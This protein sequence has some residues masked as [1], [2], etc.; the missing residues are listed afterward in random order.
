M[1]LLTCVLFVIAT[2]FLLS[3]DGGITSP[4]QSAG[5]ITIYPP[6][7][8]YCQGFNAYLKC[9]YSD[10]VIR[11]TVDGTEPNENSPIYINPIPITSSVWLRTKSYRKNR[12]PGSGSKYFYINEY[13]PIVACGNSYSGQCAIPTNTNFLDVRAGVNFSLAIKSDS[14]LIAWGSWISSP[15]PSG[16]DYKAIAAGDNHCLAL[17]SNGS[18][19]AWGDNSEGQCNRPTGFG[20]KAIDANGTLW[21]E[22]NWSLAIKSDG[23][24][25][26][27]GNN[28]YGQCNV[29]AGNH[30]VKIATGTTHGLALKDD[31]SIICWGKNDMGQTTAPP[32][33]NYTEIS[34]GDGFS[35]AL[36]SDGSISAWGDNTY[37][38]CN[39]SGESGFIAVSAG[40]GYCM[41][42]KSDHTLVSWGRGS[43]IDSSYW[44]YPGY[45]PTGNDYIKIDAGQWHCLAL[46][47]I[48]VQKNTQKQKN[49]LYSSMNF[50]HDK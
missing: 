15:I 4:V 19:E 16:Y 1:K 2:L 48:T 38:Q 20:Y 7:G 43:S 3:C 47:D 5:S 31:G 40:L 23:S 10:S 11:Y 17:H 25:I 6:N 36:K 37:G 45:A 27:W 34:A 18:I 14:S 9:Y 49:N 26:A 39:V 24:L 12:E 41:A 44:D 29:P 22:N 32:G 35:V 33:Y 28:T 46:R 21:G 13:T 50:P 42:I 30:F 8:T